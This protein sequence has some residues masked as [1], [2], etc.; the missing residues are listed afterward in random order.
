MAVVTT[1]SA[2]VTNRDSEP[3]VLNNP[4]DGAEGRVRSVF[5]KAASVSG[6]SIGSKY[7]FVAVP[8]NARITSVRLY[9]AALGVGA[10]ADIGVY[11]NTDDLGAV[12]DADFF[13]S[14]VD[15]SAAVNGTEISHESGVYTIAKREQPLWEAAGLTVDPNSTLDIVATLTG[16]SAGNGDIGVHVDFVI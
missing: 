4:N 6:D 12:V 2:Q 5:G 8:S 16:A 10:A 15:V 7:I 9:S 11:R 3:V 13:G 14:A 1:K